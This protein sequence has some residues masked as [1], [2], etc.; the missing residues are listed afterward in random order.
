MNRSVVKHTAVVEE[1]SRM[2]YNVFSLLIQLKECRRKIII[3]YYKNAI[4]DD[5]VEIGRRPGELV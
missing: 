5:L 3:V 4:A 1:T 2:I